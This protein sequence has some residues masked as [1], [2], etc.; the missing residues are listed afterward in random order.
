VRL[1]AEACWA[2]LMAGLAMATP[3]GASPRQK[4]RPK[5]DGIATILVPAGT[6]K[7]RI[8]VTV[9]RA[10]VDPRNGGNARSIEIV[11]RHGASIVEVLDTYP[12]HPQGL[13]RC[14]A[15]SETYFRVLDTVARKEVFARLI[16]SCL[17]ERAQAAHPVIT[18]SADGTTLTLNGL[19]SSVT[20]RI[21]ADGTVAVVP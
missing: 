15:G 20:I 7:V 5:S 1:R 3:A 4:A 6:H 11:G 13:S 10:N 21:G 2:M 12:S 14:Q 18:R 9:D 19:Y 16:D 17:V 8:P